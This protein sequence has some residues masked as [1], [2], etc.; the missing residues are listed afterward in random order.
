MADMEKYDEDKVSNTADDSAGLDLFIR[1]EGVDSSNLDFF[2]KNPRGL[3]P[4]VGIETICAILAA[5]GSGRLLFG[6]A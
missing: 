5:E 1:A 4:P 6:G 2:Q 3:T